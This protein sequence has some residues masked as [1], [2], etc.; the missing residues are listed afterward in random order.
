MFLVAVAAA[1]WQ[2]KGR[3]G[4]K[5]AEGSGRRGYTHDSFS[6]CCQGLELLCGTRGLAKRAQEFTVLESIAQ[7]KKVLECVALTI[8]RSGGF[9]QFERFE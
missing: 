4:Q 5:H 3:N 1:G 8:R 2:V 6:S 7:S 9:S